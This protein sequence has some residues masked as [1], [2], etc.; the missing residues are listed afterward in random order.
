ML[1]PR[2]TGTDFDRREMRTLKLEQVV[3]VSLIPSNQTFAISICAAL[4]LLT[5]DAAQ[6]W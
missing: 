3:R 4:A 2:W 6:L 1:D 5:T